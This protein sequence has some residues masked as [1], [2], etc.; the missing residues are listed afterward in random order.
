MHSAWWPASSLPGEAI[1]DHICTRLWWMRAHNRQCATAAGV[2]VGCHGASGMEITAQPSPCLV[3]CRGHTPSWTPVCSG[4]LEVSKADVS[5]VAGAGRERCY[6]GSNT[7][8]GAG[9]WHSTAGSGSCVQALAGAFSEDFLELVWLAKMTL[10][11]LRFPMVVSGRLKVLHI[12]GELN[13]YIYWHA[14]VSVPE[15]FLSAEK[16]E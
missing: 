14:L 11:S 4:L 1:L 16:C 6:P 10:V 9:C 2:Q 12:L 15:V 3:R 8:K 7:K 5:G 13:M